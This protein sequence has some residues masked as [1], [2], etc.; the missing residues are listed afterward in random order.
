MSEGVSEKPAGAALLSSPTASTRKRVP[1]WSGAIKRAS[2]ASIAARRWASPA[3]AFKVSGTL[4]DAQPLQEIALADRPEGRHAGGLGEGGEIDMR[5]EVGF[6][7]PVEKVRA[8]MTA[9]GLQRGAEAAVIVAIVD[10]QRPAAVAAQARADRG[11]DGTARFG[12]FGLGAGRRVRQ[13]AREGRDAGRQC[14]AQ[15]LAVGCQADHALGPAARR[16]VELA[17]RQGIEELV[18]DQQ[19]RARRHIVE[20]FVPGRAPGGE[21]GLLDGAQRFV[22]LDEMKIDRGVKARDAAR[23]AQGIGHQGA[24]AGSQLDQPHRRGRPIASQRSASQAPK[25]SPNICEIS[26]AVVKSPAAPS[27]R[28]RR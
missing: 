19:R 1:I 13:Q 24:A 14:K 2:A 9:H 15:R 21:G 3:R 22:D 25:S 12:D 4:H 20:A 7:G 26:G 6:A 10:D 18:G 5:A 27:G 17:H 8:A 23:G 28:A 16:L 11:G